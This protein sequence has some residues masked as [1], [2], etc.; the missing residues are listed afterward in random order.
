MALSAQ[1]LNSDA[2]LNSFR[3]VGSISFIPGEDISA[4]LRLLDTEENIRYI[5]PATN[6]TTLKFNKTDGTVLEIN[7]THLADDRS[8]MQFSLTQ[9]QTEEL[10]GG[11]ISFELDE[12]GDGTQIKKGF[13][14]NAL[15]KLTEDC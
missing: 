2:S 12:L 1:I 9:A 14:F 5:P 8:I 15:S 10:V 11:V 6:I 4:S 7:P 13:L 3:V